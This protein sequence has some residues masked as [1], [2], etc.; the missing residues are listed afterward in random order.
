[1]HAA[2]RARRLAMDNPNPDDVLSEQIQQF[3]L[4]LDSN[5]HSFNTDAVSRAERLGLYLF[6]R[7]GL[8]DL[9]F[10]GKAWTDTSSVTFEAIITGC[11]KTGTDARPLPHAIRNAIPS[12]KGKRVIAQPD[13]EC[14]V[15]LTILGEQT[16][17]SVAATPSGLL[18]VNYLGLYP[19]PPNI[20]LRIL[21]QSPGRPQ[22]DQVVGRL[23][24]L[25]N[26][27]N[28]ISGTVGRIEKT[29]SDTP[30]SA[31][32]RPCGNAFLKH[33]GGWLVRFD[34][35]E[36]FV[37]DLLGFAYIAR[38]LAQPNRPLS[39]AD[40]AAPGPVGTALASQSD[41]RLSDREALQSIRAE[42]EELDRELEH[43]NAQHDEARLARLQQERERLVAHLREITGL[44]GRARSQSS[45]RD[46]MRSA[47]TRA[48]QRAL[49]LLRTAHPSAWT[50]LGASIRT[51]E[52]MCY[53]PPEST[54]WE[55]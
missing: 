44:R 14:R 51:G 33:A 41:D 7:A 16:Q 5:W 34:G 20:R 28:D 47:V 37:R 45:A 43:A 48:I 6:C 46:Q 13:V 52:S 25:L 38:L 29:I 21:S 53:A 54:T 15:R 40:L 11:W 2:A 36:Q 10:R 49:E 23:D 17:R 32:Q 22:E 18:F 26:V 4:R 9:S 1:V 27:S 3:F 31:P 30:A 39:A 12:W 8:I 24:K 42:L 55:L 35:H 19:I 50:H